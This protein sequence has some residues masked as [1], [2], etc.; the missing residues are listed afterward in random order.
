M[1]AGIGSEDGFMSV[2]REKLLAFVA[3]AR[4]KLAFWQSGGLTGRKSYSNA[5]LFS[6]AVEGV[7]RRFGLR[8]L[9]L[10]VGQ[11]KWNLLLTAAILDLISI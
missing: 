3:I 6:C 2:A 5:S 10:I 9:L 8:C 1:A 7:A 4:G 11:E